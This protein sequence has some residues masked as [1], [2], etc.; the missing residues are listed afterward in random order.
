M[1]EAKNNLENVEPLRP[2]QLPG[3]TVINPMLQ[4]MRGLSTENEFLTLSPNSWG[5]VGIDLDFAALANA[6][7]A[8]VPDLLF[9]F[10][11]TLVAGASNSTV[12]K[13]AGGHVYLPAHAYTLADHTRTLSSGDDGRYLM[14]TMTAA[15][16]AY[17]FGELPANM[18]NLADGSFTVP[19]LKVYKQ[20][21]EWKVLHHHVGSVIFPIPPAPL[22]GGYV[23]GDIQALLH[24][25]DGSF[26]WV[27]YGDCDG[28][29]IGG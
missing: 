13:V 14:I 9:E 26:T 8:M 3:E 4:W 11:G 22:I 23:K 7:L 25:A 28:N 18:E 10:K 2:M 19:I 24:P 15:S 16:A 12:L 1:P 20:A 21:G 17:S 29:A 27:S 6:I 5:S